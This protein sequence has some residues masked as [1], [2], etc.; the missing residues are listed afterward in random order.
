MSN[1]QQMSL[2]LKFVDKNLDV[3]EEFLGL[4]HCKSGSCRKAL[5]QKLLGAISE[6]KIDINDC[7]RQG[8]DGAASVSVSKNGKA[9]HTVNKNPKAIYTH[10]F[11]HRL[12]LSIC[13][14]CKIQSFSNV[15]SKKNNDYFLTFQS[16]GNFCC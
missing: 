14:A 12:N 10:C 2:V 9:A 13:K 7:K 16:P 4:L 6:L 1:T 3:Q 8:Y 5:S 11:S 15:M